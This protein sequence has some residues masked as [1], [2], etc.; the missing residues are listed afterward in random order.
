LLAV[1]LSYCPS[2]PPMSY[3]EARFCQQQNHYQLC[4]HREHSAPERT[5]RATGGHR[6]REGYRG[7]RGASE[8]HV[9]RIRWL[10]SASK[11]RFAATRQLAIAATMVRH[12]R[13]SNRQ[14]MRR[15]SLNKSQGIPQIPAH[16]SWQR[17]SGYS[18]CNLRASPPNESRSCEKH[19]LYRRDTHIL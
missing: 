15:T 9:P 6:D 4:Q 19:A 1:L 3:A 18:T 10:A 16:Q 13:T 11:A 12:Q 17:A 5:F 8:H 14:V 2:P 7:A